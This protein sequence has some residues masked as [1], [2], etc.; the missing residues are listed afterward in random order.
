ME[1]RNFNGKVIYLGYA[2]ERKD[3]LLQIY[4][5]LEGNQVS[6]DFCI[7]DLNMG[8]Y[9]KIKQNPMKYSEYLEYVKKSDVILELQQEG[10]VGYT[11]RT[12]EA[13]VFEKKLIT[14]NLFIKNAPFY[15][16]EY[17]Q[18]ICCAQDID[19][20]W[21]KRDLPINYNYVNELS[22]YKFLKFIEESSL[23]R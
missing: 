2:K 14:N 13:I 23:C 3:L 22:P 7:P 8:N 12:W 21:I 1:E 5:Y 19:I 6:C 18:V 16:E 11:L 9:E 15:N 17:I 20:E 4:E 10:A